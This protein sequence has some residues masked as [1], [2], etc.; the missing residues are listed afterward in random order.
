MTPKERIEA[1]YRDTRP[2]AVPWFADLSN[3]FVAEKK[4]KFIPAGSFYISNEEI[5]FHKKLG[6]GAYLNM[7]AFW[8]GKYCDETVKEIVKA[9]DDLFTW[10]I[11]TPI[12]TIEEQRRWSPVSF[13]WDITKRMLK[14][15]EDMAV[16]RYA[17]ERKY[18]D[19]DY[20]RYYTME[21][22]LGDYGFIYAATGYCGIGFF[23]SRFMGVA[24]TYYALADQKEE[25]VKTFDV[26][27][28]MRLRELEVMCDS[29]CTVIFFSDNLSTGTIPPH[30]FRT[31]GADFY[32]EMAEMAHTKGKFLS[33][34]VDGTMNG[35]LPLLEECGVD[36]VDAITP[37]PM[38]DLTPAEIREQAGNMVIC[39]G[40]PATIWLSGDDDIFEDCVKEWL[41]LKEQ[42]HRLILAPGD[43][44]PPGTRIERI[45]RVREL[46]EQFGTYE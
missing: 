34:H 5:E 26:I 44:V 27:N 40:I 29:P 36:G 33:V 25:V 28:A 32:T 16:L 9:D 42:S 37:A 41:E 30:Y 3:W 45:R 21:E 1:V 13:S 6:V 46:N 19:P 17:F 35:L 15:T 4:I 8:K 14:T 31:Y 12:G 24:N 22:K 11:E 7:G 10:T 23:I 39:G 38:G 43:Q 18:F 20:E 2:D